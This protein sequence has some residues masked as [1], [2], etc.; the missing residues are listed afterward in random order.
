M[1]TQ[2]STIQQTAYPHIVKTEGV[3]G[4][5]AAIAP[6]ADRRV[7]HRRILLQGGNVR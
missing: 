2:N 7:A 1:V 4:G 6:N 3:V 5:Q